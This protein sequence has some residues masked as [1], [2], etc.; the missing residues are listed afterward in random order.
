[1]SGLINIMLFAQNWFSED[2]ILEISTRGL[3]LIMLLSAPMLLSAL[4]VGLVISIIQATTQI[5]EQ[6]LASV[7]KMA[8]TFISLIVCGPWIMDTLSTYATELFQYIALMGP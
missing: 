7:P 5:Q 4:S 2:F 8:V 3:F 1:M 6:T